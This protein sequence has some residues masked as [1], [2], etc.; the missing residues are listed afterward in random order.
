MGVQ[1]NDPLLV[2]AKEEETVMTERLDRAGAE[3]DD[4][5]LDRG[6]GGGGG[7]GILQ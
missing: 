4:T 3:K 7:G 5:G 2:A 1:W 6:G